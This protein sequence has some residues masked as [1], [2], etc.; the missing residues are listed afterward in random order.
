MSR[1][2]FTVEKTKAGFQFV[3]PGTERPDPPPR[4][5]YA[6]DR[7]NGRDQFVLPGAERIGAGAL[8]TRLMA[9]PLRPRRG[10]KSLVGTALFGRARSGSDATTMDRHRATS[11][12]TAA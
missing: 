10:Q 8:A 3:I 2:R 9:L 6:V 11:P 7:E 12:R 5:R 1:E 4:I